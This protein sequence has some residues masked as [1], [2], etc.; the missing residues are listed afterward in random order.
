[1]STREMPAKLLFGTLVSL[2]LPSA[3]YA[4][5]RENEYL[6]IKGSSFPWFAIIISSCVLLLIPLVF[7]PLYCFYRRKNKNKK[8]M[9]LTTQFHEAKPDRDWD[10]EDGFTTP[11]PAKPRSSKR[12][13]EKSP[14]AV[15]PR[16]D[17]RQK[18]RIRHHK[19]LFSKPYAT[20]VSHQQTDR[21][22]LSS[23]TRRKRRTA[24]RTQDSVSND[25]DTPDTL[26]LK[27]LASCPP[28]GEK[29]LRIVRRAG[30]ILDSQ[31]S[32]TIHRTTKPQR[33][34]RPP[35]DEV[36]VVAADDATSCGSEMTESLYIFEGHEVRCLPVLK[37]S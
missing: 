8:R 2:L 14:W 25:S 7:G 26:S 34:K 19:F 4:Q 24:A 17:D 6:G 21:H 11:P 35:Q 15:E 33:A 5:E 36:V 12:D 3:V 20:P 28:R 1:M 32:V 16:M 30:M 31:R 37:L 23:K 18:E 13:R 22:P 10:L 27:A 29:I 9:S